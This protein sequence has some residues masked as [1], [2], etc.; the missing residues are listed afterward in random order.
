MALLNVGATGDTKQLLIIGSIAVMALTIVVHIKNLQR[1]SK[2]DEHY[3]ELE[4][5]K[6]E[7]KELKEAS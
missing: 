4:L 3:T 5:M 1:M 2:E 6:A 7:I